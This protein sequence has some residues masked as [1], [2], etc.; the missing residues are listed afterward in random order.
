MKVS[1]KDGDW[2]ERKS[3]WNPVEAIQEISSSLY[4][5]CR[6]VDVGGMS[7]LLLSTIPE[8]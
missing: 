5:K 6:R 7:T 2:R 1:E 4:C 3:E 8:V